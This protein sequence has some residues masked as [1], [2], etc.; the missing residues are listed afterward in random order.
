MTESTKKTIADKA[1]S[2]GFDAIGFCGSDL[3]PDVRQNFY[4][5]LSNNY[6]GDMGW[7]LEKA[8]WRS[9]P[10]NLWPEAKSVIVLGHNYAPAENPLEKLTKKN[11][12]NISCYAQNNDYH[13]IIKKK[14]KE[15]ARFIV[16]EYGGDV[17]VFVDTAPVMEKPLAAQA[18][19]GWQGKHTCLV[20]REFGS[21][22]FL[23]AIFTTLD[24]GY[25]T[26]T[27]S[28]LSRGMENCG[29]CTRCLDICP[30][31]AFTGARQIDARKCISYL[32]IE[33]KGQIPLEYR[34]AIGNRIYGCDDCLAVCPWNKF[35]KTAQE[36]AYHPREE[37]KAPLL[38]DLVMLDDEKFRNLFRK[39]PVKR[40]GHERFIR[41]VLIAIGNSGDV[42]L[43]NVI[44]PLA[45]SN[46]G[47][48]KEMANWA[49][50]ELNKGTNNMKHV[51]IY[52]KDYCPYCVK[53]KSLLTHKG[54]SNV[55]EID[56]THD[57]K[58]QQEMINKSGGRRTVPQIFIGDT[59]VGG[60]DELYALEKEGKLTTLLAG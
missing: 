20:S 22:L 37:L 39:S 50:E 8:A 48:I 29:S 14:L 35:A 56:I 43:I 5:F 13:D 42:S 52:T 32:T 44:E 11:I 23:G 15:L 30:T 45:N 57:E 7:M 12:G 28:P 25:N 47:L 54:V 21:W 4:S 17:K 6:H 53:A 10:D 26:T 2:I 58:L 34:K 16:R 51:T 60:C 33:N 24:L 59:H 38:K 36:A 19:L 9:S 3:P 18:E 49:I 40:I 41:N 1:K 27:R 31:Q 55:A 46:S